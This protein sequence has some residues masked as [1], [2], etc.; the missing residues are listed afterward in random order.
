V[1]AFE[2][3]ADQARRLGDPATYG[4]ALGLYSG[5]LLPDDP[6]DDWVVLRREALHETYLAL[7]GGLADLC[8][9]AGDLAGAIDRSQ[10]VVEDDPSRS[11]KTTRAERMR[12]S[13]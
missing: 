13:S 7:L 5:F 6:Y 9:R 11:W 10:R 12:T 3:A 1:E 4:R 2:C 8:E